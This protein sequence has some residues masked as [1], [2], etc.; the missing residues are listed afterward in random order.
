MRKIRLL[1]CALFAF[2][3]SQA[4]Q[5]PLYSQYALNPFMYNPAYTADNNHSDFYLGARR[6]WASMNSAVETKYITAQSSFSN[7]KG[8]I[9][10]SFINDLSEFTRKNTLT[11]NYRYR[12]A[13]SETNYLSLG[14]AAGVWDN[15]IDPNKIYTTDVADPVYQLIS[16][17]G[18]MAFTSNAG[19]LYRNGGLHL[20]LAIPNLIQTKIKYA[21]NYINMFDYSEARHIV[22][23][24][25]YDLKPNEDWTISPFVW[26]KDAGRALDG[27]S[28]LGVLANFR[29]VFWLSAAY[30]QH[31]AFSGHFG[32]RLGE[33]FTVAYTYDHPTGTYSKALGGSHEMVLGWRIGKQTAATPAV[34]PDKKPVTTNDADNEVLIKQNKEIDNLKNQVENLEQRQ[35]VLETE[36]KNRPTKPAE[37]YPPAETKIETPKKVETPTPKKVETPTTTTPAANTEA[38]EYGEFVLI[39][40]SFSDQVNAMKF[41]KFL[42]TKGKQGS[43]YFDDNNKVHYVYIGKHTMK[44]KAIE[45][46]NSLAASGIQTWVKNI[47]K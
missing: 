28:D 25:Q 20:G 32:M 5:V 47:K 22:L 41:I 37:N 23:N 4:Q 13:F 2:V 7:N 11:A 30:R 1:L 24:A 10:V 33:K 26:L 31:Y 6:Q 42:S 35:K 40:G 21:D 29:D 19:I 27:Q 8:G 15:Q 18:G 9:G 12:V 36:Q 44:S 17:R 34:V 14:L 45:S 39:A 46:K 38:E 3:A 43:Y 16:T